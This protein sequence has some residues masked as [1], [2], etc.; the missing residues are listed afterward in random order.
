MS[1]QPH[2]EL[3]N[4]WIDELRAEADRARAARIAKRSRSRRTKSHLR[5]LLQQP[6]AVAA[7]VNHLVGAIISPPWRTKDRPATPSRV[8]P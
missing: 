2:T 3:A 6:I 7:A 1:W 4:Q 8:E 5:R